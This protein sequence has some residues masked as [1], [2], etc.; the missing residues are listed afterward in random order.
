MTTVRVIVAGTTGT[1]KT[2][3]AWLIE[4]TLWDHGVTVQLVDEECNLIEY[5]TLDGRLAAVAQLT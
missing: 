3:V 1:G 4:K 5:D 2:T